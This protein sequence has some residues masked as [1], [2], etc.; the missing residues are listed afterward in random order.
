[1]HPMSSNARLQPLIFLY[2]ETTIQSHNVHLNP[3]LLNLNLIIEK[4][5]YVDERFSSKFLNKS[6]AGTGSDPGTFRK[7]FLSTGALRGDLFQ[8]L[9]RSLRGRSL[10]DLPSCLAV[11]VTTS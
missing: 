11:S 7:D 2:I 4:Q 6:S 1:M 5:T 9:G 3:C 10:R 8:S